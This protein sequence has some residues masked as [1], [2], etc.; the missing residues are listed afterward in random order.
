[1]KKQIKLF[2]LVLTAALLVG[3]LAVSA[4][5]ATGY[6]YTSEASS[7]ETGESFHFYLHEFKNVTSTPKN[8]SI[9]TAALK[10]DNNKNMQFASGYKGTVSVQKDNYGNK[11]LQTHY[12][13]TSTSTASGYLTIP[14]GN[15]TESTTPATIATYKSL[16]DLKYQVM[17][18]DVF[19]PNGTITGNPSMNLQL[20][21]YLKMDAS[22]TKATV[23]TLH[24]NNL[25]YASSGSS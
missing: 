15:A 17:D 7:P 6:D 11:Y 24:S 4:F 18:F 5:A 10:S 25:G 12:D 1:M 19:F 13:S 9:S 3:A 14:T 22:A 8:L 21:A 20:R 2:A 16:A 23:S